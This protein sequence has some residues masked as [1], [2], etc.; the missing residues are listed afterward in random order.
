MRVSNAIDELKH[1]QEKFGD[2]P[3]IIDSEDDYVPL[4]SIRPMKWRGDS[5]VGLDFEIGGD[6][7]MK[8]SDLIKVLEAENPDKFVIVLTLDLDDQA[9]EGV[10]IAPQYESRSDKPEY[11]CFY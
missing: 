9:L 3:V 6:S 4:N 5:F 2:L 11:F 10:A 8:T 7:A 1:Y